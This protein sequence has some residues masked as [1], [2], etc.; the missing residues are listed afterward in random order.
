LRTSTG[1]IA[2]T[3]PINN[4]RLQGHDYFRIMKTAGHQ[5]LNVFKYYNPVSHPRRGYD[6]W[7]R[8]K[9][10]AMDPNLGTSHHWTVKGPS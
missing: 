6:P 3:R 1:T 10:A 7:R 4:W 5:T 9:T 8:R 2:D